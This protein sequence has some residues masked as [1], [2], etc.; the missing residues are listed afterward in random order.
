MTLKYWR[1]PLREAEAE[2]DA[3]RK[4]SEFNLAARA[5]L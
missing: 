4:R 2:L 5:F 1:R 3:A